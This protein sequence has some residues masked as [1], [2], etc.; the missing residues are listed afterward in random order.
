MDY[1]QREKLLR[2]L[3]T[4]IIEG[5]LLQADLVCPVC[6][7]SKV[8]YSFTRIPYSQ[9][10]GLFIECIRCKY[11]QHYSLIAKPPNFTDELVLEKYQL[12]EDRVS[13]TI[14]DNKNL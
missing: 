13:K 11:R 5:D 10:Y 6:K 3:A 7:K 14:K 9:R 8:I 1:I 2:A 12:L 4:T